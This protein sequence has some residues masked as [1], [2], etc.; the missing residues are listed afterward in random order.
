MLRSMEGV[1]RHIRVA[2]PKTDIAQMHFAMPG[3]LADYCDGRTP[4][5]IEQ[6]EKVANHYGC[7]SLNLTLE[8]ADRIAVEEFTWKSGFKNNVHPPPFGQTVYSNSMTR[9]LD[10]AFARTPAPRSHLIPNDLID[11]HSYWQGKFGNLEDA[12]IVKGF[13]LVPKWRPDNGNIREG[14]VDVPALVAS[15]AGSEFEYT[16]DGTAFGLFLA[17]GHDTCVLEFSVDGGSWIRKD[18]HTKWSKSLHLPWPVILVDGLEDGSHKIAVRTTNQVKTRTSIH[19][20][21][22][23][24]NG[25]VKN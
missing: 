7:P 24:I 2:N 12:R 22:V 15:E 17:A 8:V 1:V 11:P 6:H 3:H 5:P 4:A 18:T 16:F 10:A 14:F 19:V 13:S 21:H 25:V 9:M 23:L 20:V